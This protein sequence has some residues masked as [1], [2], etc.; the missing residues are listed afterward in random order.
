STA[1]YTALSQPDAWT[2]GNGVTQDWSYSSP[3]QRLSQL[4]VGTA[5]NRSYSYDAVGNV[6]SIADNLNAANSQS[7]GYDDRNRLSSWTLGG[8]SQSYAYDSI[9][10]L[11]SKSGL[12]SY[13]YGANGNGTGSGPHQAR[14]AGGV[15]YSYDSNGNTT[16]GNTWSYH[17][18]AD[19]TLHD[20]TNGA[21]TQTHPHDPHRD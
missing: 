12:G 10:N 19:N 5:F 20:M 1:S 9:G 2:F 7:F 16:S 8:S 21:F 13:N 4:Q 17:W 3:M 6:Q 18:N 11:T 15:G 14:Q